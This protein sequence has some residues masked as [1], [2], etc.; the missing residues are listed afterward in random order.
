MLNLLRT[1]QLLILAAILGSS[2]TAIAQP[3]VT[4]EGR[5]FWFGFMP[6]YIDPADKLALFIASGT[7]NRVEIQVYGQNE[8][9][10]WTKVLNFTAND[11]QRV[12]LPVAFAESQEFETPVYRAIRVTSSS[13]CTVVG[14]SDNALSSDA[15]LAIPL[16]S[17]GTV[18]YCASY[19]DDA[20]NPGVDQLGGE[21]LI[22]AP[23]D[24]TRV[25]ITTTA[26]TALNS[27]GTTVGHTIGQTWSVDLNRGQTYLVR[28]TGR[29]YGVED[30]TGSKVTSNKPIGFLSGHQRAEIELEDGNSKDHLI[31]MIPS[32]IHWGTEYF[33]IPQQSRPIAGNYYRVISA[34]DGNTIKVNDTTVV[35]N[36]GQYAAFSQ[37]TSAT[38]F[39]STNKRRFLAVEYFYDEGHFGDPGPG[40]PDMTVL[41][42]VSDGLRSAMF[43]TPSNA[44]TAFKH[45]AT[46]IAPTTDIHTLTLKKGNNDPLSLSAFGGVVKQIEGTQ[47]SY[48][49]LQLPGDEIV[50]IA[51]CKAPFTMTL[52][53]FANVESYGYPGPRSFA[54]ASDSVKPR[55]SIDYTDECGNRLLK[56]TDKEGIA[57]LKLLTS[58]DVEY[59]GATAHT[60]NFTMQV[61]PEFKPG[62]TVVNVTL[63]LIDHAKPASAALYFIDEG[64]HDSIYYTSY[65][66]TPLE[67][68]IDAPLPEITRLGDTICRVLT[69]RNLHTDSIF[70]TPRTMHPEAAFRISPDEEYWLQPNDSLKFDLCFIPTDT[71]TYS[72]SILVTTNCYTTG[73]IATSR[74]V[75]ARIFAPD[76]YYGI[77]QKGTEIC[78]DFELENR[79]EVPVLITGYQQSGDTSFHVVSPTF[80]FLL[81]PNDKATV[82]ICLTPSRDTGNLAA[83]IDWL[84][85]RPTTLDKTFTLLTAIA[86]KSGVSSVVESPI[87]LWPNPAEDRINLTLQANEQ[88]ITLTAIDVTGHSYPL[89]PSGSASEVHA[90]T[91]SL[92]AGAYR[93]H[94]ETSHGQYVLP[95]V[96]KR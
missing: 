48:V 39:I 9:I 58:T 68:T 34:E 19:Y 57:D 42:P 24:G 14:Y 70:V 13:P 76:Q 55:F 87:V 65:T 90:A 69:V 94:L 10:I 7:Q 22:I 92:P 63:T 32:T 84:L 28:S 61:S 21:F 37:M 95:L 2:I 77:V 51:D 78:R 71:L 93:L 15:F 20:Y 81:E 26:N 82:R 12:N 8:E 46:F 36:A 38:H 83:R 62:D 45:Y 53:G 6:N 40:D 88:I 47:Y 52:Y 4:S 41:T 54:S 89:I 73:F 18:H 29:A 96:I 66:P 3:G 44:G 31:E 80:P 33:G 23:Y 67:W 75:R 43:R 27:S 56:L 5:E 86:M 30:L 64:S 72:D 50:W 1:L 74:A 17:L 59:Y 79:S 85:D 16:H 49:R 35:I 11:A 25:T 60:E 91:I